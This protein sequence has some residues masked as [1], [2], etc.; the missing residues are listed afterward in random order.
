MIGRRSATNSL[1]SIVEY[2]CYPAMVL[3]TTPFFL[4]RIGTE[5]FGLWALMI[6]TC[7]LG[8]LLSGGTAAATIKQVSENIG[9]GNQAARTH[10][11]NRALGVAISGGLL[12]GLAVFLVF[13]VAGNR[14]FP[15]IQIQSA[16]TE[17]GATAAF[18]IVL[19]QIG[20]VLAASLKGTEK[21]SACAKLELT[22]RLLQGAICIV[23]I[24]VVR[25]V[26]ALFVAMMF[27]YTARVGIFFAVAARDLGTVRP[28]FHS[29]GGRPFIQLTLWGWIQGIGQVLFG[30]ADRFIIGSFLGATSLAQYSIALMLPMQIHAVAAAA[31]AIIFPMVSKNLG[32][33]T[34]FSMRSLLI[35]SSF[36]NLAL[37]TVIALTLILFG[38]QI[39]NLWLGNQFWASSSGIF[40]WLV[41]AYWLLAQNITAYF[42]LLGMGRMRFVGITL[43]L[44]GLLG[45]LVTVILVVS[46][47]AVGAAIGRL[48]FSVAT[49][50]LFVPLISTRSN[51]PD[52]RS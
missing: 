13:A 2:A 17:I 9:R 26:E 36:A 12:L 34:G 28:L 5:H 3:V 8:A 23:S 47:G 21:F 31:S 51:A 43:W 4:R 27:A 19:D 14:L 44:C 42:A 22:S 16:L 46:L 35:R 41:V 25:S 24:E 30:A 7:G 50:A 33:S 29:I 45:L 32:A 18:V 49:L 52:R 10:T 40:L 20:A 15:K 48:A 6:A 1:W 39:T 11:V 37:S 38:E